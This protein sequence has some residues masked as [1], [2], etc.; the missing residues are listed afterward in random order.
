MSKKNLNPL[1]QEL[2]DLAKECQKKTGKSPARIAVLAGNNSQLFK[3]LEE[4]GGC[5]IDTFTA[6]KLKIAELMND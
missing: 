2:I 6:I 3:T 1:A 4:G 5:N